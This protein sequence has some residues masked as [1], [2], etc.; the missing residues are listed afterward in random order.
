MKIKFSIENYYDDR[1]FDILPSVQYQWV[2]ACQFW[3]WKRGLYISWFFWG[4]IIT[5]YNN[6]IAERFRK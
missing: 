3:E 2:P 6:K 5:A 1:T 4:I